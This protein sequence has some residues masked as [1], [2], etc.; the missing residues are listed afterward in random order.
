MNVN[1]QIRQ[2]N[3]T[4]NEVKVYNSEYYTKFVYDYE[5][6]NKLNPNKWNLS[7]MYP[8]VSKLA[9]YIFDFD[10]IDKTNIIILKYF[11]LNCLMYKNNK[12]STIK[13]KFIY[14]RSFIIYFQE[15]NLDMKSVTEYELEEFVEFEKEKKI[16][17]KT[18]TDRM[19]WIIHLFS[20]VLLLGYITDDHFSEIRN[21]IMEFIKEANKIKTTSKKIGHKSIPQNLY[22]KLILLCR[23]IIYDKKYCNK[24]KMVASMII[25]LSDTGMRIDDYRRLKINAIENIKVNDK[26]YK[27]LVFGCSKTADVYEGEE[28]VKC[29]ISEHTENAY[30]TILKITEKNRRISGSNFLILNRES[31]PFYDA[32]SFGSQ[33][34]RFI[35]KYDNYLN[36]I[37]TT[38]VEIINNLGVKSVE[39]IKKSRIKSKSL[40]NLLNKKSQQNIYYITPHQFRV[41]L[42]NRL[43]K[44]GVHIHWIKRHMNHLHEEITNSYLRSEIVKDKESNVLLVIEKI[45]RY[46]N[47]IEKDDEIGNSLREDLNNNN[48]KKRYERIK[49]F[50]ELGEV[51]V[52]KSLEEI[53]SNSSEFNNSIIEV[54]LGYCIR[55]EFSRLCMY[56]ESKFNSIQSIQELVIPDVMLFYKTIDRFYEMYKI[57]QYNSDMISKG[58]PYEFE[59]LRSREKL[60]RFIKKSLI[61]EFEMYESI[62]K[63]KEDYVINNIES[64]IKDGVRGIYE[65]MKKAKIILEMK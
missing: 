36:C 28:I 34:I 15:K 14:L 26:S 54:E 61:P 49:E 58:M 24:D 5:I 29:I 59:L 45:K 48:I 2:V 40:L 20:I 46:T 21:T 16:R 27:Y 33:L 55:N 62:I 51:K 43:Y 1:Y 63:Q 4:V 10:K 32:S 64:K 47:E 31:K 30:N 22:R 39:E 23:E 18:F 57:F 44:K 25:I 53:I 37:D 7:N 12:P 60:K 52:E 65:C 38:D 19:S 35:I 13:D 41:T 42:C 9:E 3:S 17:R 56:E 8:I 50:L 11:V 6:K